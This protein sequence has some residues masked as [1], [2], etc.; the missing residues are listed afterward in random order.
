LGSGSVT[1][2]V[3]LPT[4]LQLVGEER[5]VNAENAASR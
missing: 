5:G 2:L 4:R 1:H 3:T